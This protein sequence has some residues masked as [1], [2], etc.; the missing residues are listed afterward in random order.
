MAAPSPQLARPP[1]SGT[2]YQQVKRAGWG[3]GILLQVGGGTSLTTSWTS[4]E[5]RGLTKAPG[6]VTA[7]HSKTAF[8]LA[9]LGH[10]NT[11]EPS[12]TDSC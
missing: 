4:R 1:A 9:G 2:N 11:E 7:L 6:N 12:D 5:Y 8:R 3:S 10:A